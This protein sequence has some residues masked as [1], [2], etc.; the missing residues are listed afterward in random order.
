VGECGFEE[1]YSYDANGRQTTVSNGSGTFV[2][3]YS[4]SGQVLETANLSGD[5]VSQ[6]VWGI[7]YVNHLIERDDNT[8]SGDLGFTGSGLGVR[9]YAITDANYNVTGLV[10]TSANVLERFQFTAYGI[11]SELTADYVG[12]GSDAYGFAP[13]F[14]GGMTD[15]VTGLVH[16]DAR[17]YNPVTGRWM[18]RDPLGSAYVDGANLYAFEGSEPV[19]C[20]DYTG[21]FAVSMKFNAFIPKSL[22]M[23]TFDGKDFNWQR[24]PD[25]VADDILGFLDNRNLAT[26]LWFGTDNRESAGDTGTSRI[27]T[28]TSLQSGDVGNLSLT[29]VKLAATAGVSHQL[30]AAELTNGAPTDGQDVRTNT[31]KV[32]SDI[33]EVSNPSSCSSDVEIKAS[34]NYPFG[35][36][37]PD[38]KMDVT[39]NLQKTEPT[40]ANSPIKV[41]VSGSHTKFPYFEGIANG[42]LLYSF[43]SSDSGPG[44]WNLGSFASHDIK[45]SDVTPV[46]LS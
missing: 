10:D 38:I 35:L 40:N 15:P 34:A 44:F 45:S 41:S 8:T 4:T 23:S 42:H 21:E 20:L 31:A 17:D 5:A 7:D 18:E 9:I 2:S 19:I 16:F 33:V 37:S 32:D 39:W 43:S 11:R 28:T 29:K 30:K 46:T 24:E 26:Y 36:Y 12:L 25:H 14:Q 22:G 27:T 13:G 1:T 6:Y 3:Y